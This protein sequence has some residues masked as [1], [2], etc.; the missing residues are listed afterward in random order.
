MIPIPDFLKKYIAE[1]QELVSKGSVQDI[2]F[3]GSTY[4]IKVHDD[5]LKQDC[6]S[7]VQLDSQGLLQ[8]AFCSCQEEEQHEGCAHLV[9]SLL[10]IYSDSV[11]PLH[12]RY[13][14]S[15]WNSLGHLFFKH[16]GAHPKI[17][18][19]G[20]GIKI[21]PNFHL[22]LEEK[23]IKQQ[24]L[25]I[26]ESQPVENEENSLKFS[27]LSEKELALWRKGH[28]SEQLQYELSVWSDFAR[29]L[30]I[31][32]DEQL[33]NNV[34]FDFNTDGLPLTIHAHFNQF[35]LSYQFKGEE[36]TDIVDSLATIDSN[37]K[38]FNKLQD[39]VSGI[40][41]DEKKQSL[42]LE[43]KPLLSDPGERIVF[44]RWFYLPRIGFYPRQT[45]PLLKSPSIQKDKIAKALD[46]YAIEIQPLIE[47]VTLQL[48]P[49]R[50]NY[51]L[52]FD[53]QFDLHITTYIFEE[54]DLSQPCSRLFGHWAFIEK[55]GFYR[56]YGLEFP[57]AKSVIKEADVPDF[58]RHH[59]GWLNQQDGFKIHLQSLEAQ[60]VYQVDSIGRLSFN[61]RIALSAHENRTKDFGSWIYVE[62]EGFYSKS[63][64][65]ISLPLQS[66]MKM[67]NDQIPHFIHHNRGDLELVQNFF[68]P[69][70]PFTEIGLNVLLTSQSSIEIV[71]FFQIRLEYL[72]KRLRFYDDIVYVEEVGFYELPREMMLPENYTEKKVLKGSKVKDFIREDLPSLM[73][74]IS[75]LDPRL[76]A[77]K[78][79]HLHAA[80]L[81]RQEDDYVVR[82]KYCTD[83]GEI[84]FVQVYQ[85][86][87]QKLPYLFSFYGLID[88]HSSCFDWFRSVKE[89]QVDMKENEIHFSSIELIRLNALEDLY[90]DEDSKRILHDLVETKHA[91]PI[92]LNGLKSVLRPYQDKGVQW[93]FSLYEYGL[94][95][96]LCDDMGL[97]KTHQAMAL[98][99]AVK[100]AR[101]KRKTRF[102]V[103]CPT[104]VLYHWQEK[105]Q[106]FLPDLEVLTFHG[107]KRKELLGKDYDILLTSYGILRNEMKYFQ[108]QEFTIAIFD[109]I[110]V[111]KNFQSRLY[112]SLLNI[113]SHMR[114]GLTGTPIENRLRELKA[115]FD[116]ILP[117]YMPADTEFNRLYVKPVERENDM[118]QKQKLVRL[119]KPFIL[120]R[121]KEDVLLD[122]PDKTEEMAHCDMHPEQAKLYQ[123]VLQQGRERILSDLVDP[124]KTIPYIH[125]F[126]LLSHLKQVVDHPALYL[127]KTEQYKKYHSGKWDLFIE[128]LQ[129]ARESEQKVVIF[130]Q[131]LGM[132]D[133]IENYLKANGIGFAGI[134][135]VTKDRSEQIKIFHQDPKCE[136]FVASLK[137]A[138]LGI[139]LTPASIVIHYDRWWNK[140]REDQA[141]D[142]VHRIGQ[143]RNVQVFKLM[144]KKTFE[145]RIHELIQRKGQLMED[146][147]GVD[148][149]EVL[150]RFS[151]DEL[152]HLLQDIPYVDS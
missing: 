1:A 98:F 13:E 113:R 96:L 50:A 70:C 66:G 147:V 25:E 115:L 84:P 62:D 138:G 60:I 41:Y 105:L 64:A 108:K 35:T 125:V 63:H 90:A 99:A 16:Y 8:D 69:L 75:Q 140:A 118:Q 65:S 19:E 112:N 85:A 30:T 132:L 123:F 131:Y 129:E 127:K 128:L 94:S 92:N 104:S 26:F 82:L 111:A 10:R 52:Q 124:S 11:N 152:M 53:K 122:L 6:W 126:A 141:T 133:I 56:I 114:L 146:V 29:W 80:I 21:G 102:L 119:I 97:G 51:F 106:E 150:K 9:A 18:K 40:T 72:G 89:N 58:I 135:G 109:E 2:Q 67:S 37:L 79:L 73:P 86:Y 136:V 116:I 34:T 49:A 151:R 12:L 78:Y 107:T 103:V 20:V 93:L 145:E 47:G 143:H 83:K 81:N 88:L 117:L 7:F 61:K 55:N 3:S 36:F 71:P 32:Q 39:F 23:N 46:E 27:N 139:D 144:T 44:S 38:V 45:H 57:Q 148:D 33:L 134:R 31:K 28:P 48:Q 4:Q 22:K 130:S 15:I 59:V 14:I 137:A 5:H 101:T 43:M 121:K 142:R 24:V 100:N 42:S 54:N 95:G 91:I 149:H 74:Y 120:R 76:V 17:S 68:A 110:Q 77:P 87:R